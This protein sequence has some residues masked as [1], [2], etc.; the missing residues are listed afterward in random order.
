MIKFVKQVIYSLFR[1]KKENRKYRV[2]RIIL[3]LVIKLGAFKLTIIIIKNKIKILIK[4]K[5]IIGLI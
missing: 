3:N 4:I 2:K 5:L 1:L